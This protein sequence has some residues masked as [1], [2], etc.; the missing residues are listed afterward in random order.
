MASAAAAGTSPRAVPPQTGGFGLGFQPPMQSPEPKRPRGHQQAVPTVID[1]GTTLPQ[2]ITGLSEIHTRVGSAEDFASGIHD[3]VD[4][5]ALVL[6][7]VMLRLVALEA[8]AAQT[9][10]EMA[11]ATGDIGKLGKLISDADAADQKLDTQL[12]A[13]LNSMESQL[14]EKFRVSEAA[15]SEKL[16]VLEG[17]ARGAISATQVLNGRV[18]AMGGLLGSSGPSPPPGVPPQMAQDFGILKQKLESAEGV[19]RNQGEQLNILVGQ[20]QATQSQIFEIRTAVGELQAVALARNSATLGGAGLRSEAPGFGATAQ[21]EQEGRDMGGHGW[22]LG[23]MFGGQSQGQDGQGRGG[24]GAAQGAFIGTPQRT[25]GFGGDGPGRGASGFGGKWFLYDE[26][27]VLSGKGNYDHKAPQQWLQTLRD[28]LAGR[29]DDLDAILDW[30]ERQSQPIGI[31]PDAGG[32]SFPMLMSCPVDSREISRQ[33]WAFLGPLIVSDSNKTSIYKNVQRHNGLEAWRKIAE[34]IN[35]DKM[36]ILQELL[37]QITNPKPA[38]DMLGF[39]GAMRDWQTTIRLYTEAGGEKPTGEPERMAFIRLLPPD[40]AAH[41]LLHQ[42]LPQYA[43]FDNLKRFTEQYVKVML[44]LNRQRK[45][46]AHSHLK[47]VEASLDDYETQ[48]VE[49][50][51]EEEDMPS[52]PC[53]QIGNYSNMDSDDQVEVL[54]FMKARGFTPSGRTGNGRFV[55]SP[56]GGGR[57][58]P[59]SR[60]PAAQRYMPPRGASDM[61]CINCAR[62]GHSAQDCPEPKR[63]R[64]ARLCF[65]CNKPGHESRACPEPKKGGPRGPFQGRAP[66]KAVTSGAAAQSGQKQ[67][68]CAVTIPKTDSDGYT[69]VRGGPRQQ[70]AQFGDFIRQAAAE[71]RS[72]NRFRPLSLQEWQD[73]ASD[74]NKVDSP[75]GEKAVH[76]VAPAT[77]PPSNFPI[78]PPKVM[79]DISIDHCSNIST[80]TQ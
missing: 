15:T 59:G 50:E 47:L 46:Q 79:H 28:Y 52:M 67:W 20:Q 51:Q 38:T 66:V 53:F 24:D 19:Q 31:S 58:Q 68:V 16:T 37:P 9:S 14:G 42:A 26:K 18:D 13:E 64:S 22:P 10:G 1:A 29:C 74:H 32:D 70:P 40:V 4:H 34:P 21:A 33:L 55:K 77:L 3:A 49:E 23:G 44:G 56:G 36:M 61:T 17:I 72:T 8:N 63:E 57:G 2:L 43:T 54:A 80:S 27:Y 45:G 7:A 35:D 71:K 60:P 39:E 75:K 25:G 69:L 6:E 30:A 76:A 65:N 62:K 5:N 73:I 48:Y 78:L 12:R 11:Q 41:V